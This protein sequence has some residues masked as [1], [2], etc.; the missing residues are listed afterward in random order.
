MASIEKRSNGSYRIT[1][2][3]G[4][5]PNG[6]KD[7]R[8]KSIKLPDGLTER[9]KEKEI[10]KQAVLFEQQ[11]ASGTYLD[12]EKITFAEF[13]ERWMSEYAEKHLA[14]KTVFEYK[15]QLTSR[16]LPAIGHIKLCKLQPTH[17][18][19][20][21]NNLGEAGMR[22]DTKYLLKLE[23][24]EILSRE[25]KAI[26]VV[27]ESTLRSISRGRPTTKV[28]ASR[29][30]DH[31]NISIG[32]MFAPKE[33][34]GKLSSNSINHYHRL[35][36]SI[37][38]AAV[39]WQVIPSN[40]CERV[41]PPKIERKEARHYDD[42]EAAK[43]F[44]LLECEPIKYQAAI[45]IAVF[46]GL[47][48]GETTAIEWADVNFEKNIIKID[49]AS[50]Y[51]PDKGSFDGSPKTDKSRR[52]VALPEIAM[53]KLR[54]HKNEQDQH[55]IKMGNLWNHHDK[56]FTQVDGKPM[57]KDTPSKWFS[58]WLKKNDMPE[59]VFHGLRHTH[60]SLLI[61]EGVDVATVSRR[62][63]HASIATTISVYTH[64]I[65]RK[66]IEAADKLGELFS[67][68]ASETS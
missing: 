35:I 68:K 38:T 30:S 36:S 13:S 47:R 2:S 19:E 34:D 37:M 58:K 44:E 8:H 17:L 16:L 26:T 21:Y 33:A 23:Y 67:L 4:Y 20:L 5:L 12:G 11:V 51:V 50:Q 49:K 54:L 7:R 3:C 66:D 48:L 32:E 62:L 9:Q 24:M 10:Q 41:K 46:G 29:I 57:F 6:K 45:Y 39:Q 60:A 42:A 31:C 53:N 43:M 52:E 56:V 15:N 61:A 28:I 55:R 27:S 40:P 22:A 14:P 18:I 59:L 25:R 64:P 1:V 65:Q 63:G